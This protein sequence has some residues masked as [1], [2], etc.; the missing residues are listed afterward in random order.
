MPKL[1]VS[2]MI[3][4]MWLVLFVPIARAQDAVP[5][6]ETAKVLQAMYLADADR[7]EFFADA[8]RSVALRREPMPV[9]HWASHND[10]SGDLFVW[11]RHGRAEIIGCILSGPGGGANRNFYHEFHALSVKPLPSQGLPDGKEWAPV[12]AGLEFQPIPDAPSPAES[13]KTRL[14]QMRSLA[15][16]FDVHMDFEGSEWKL[17]LLPQPIFRYRRPADAAGLDWLDGAVFAFVMT[18]GTDAEVL[19]VLEA[20]KVE[21]GWQWQYAPARI[22]NKPAW[23]KRDDKEIWRVGGYEHEAGLITRPY[24]TFYA[25]SKAVKQPDQKLNTEN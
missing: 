13:D 9:M 22:T 8:E 15:R 7:Y 10:W 6:P 23:M 21:N 24:T 3:A 11:E 1:T 5:A 20:R 12:T 18:T 25:E 19:M 14:T 2:S 16:D 4:G 17:R